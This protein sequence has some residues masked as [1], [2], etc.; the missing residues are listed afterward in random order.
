VSVFALKDA[1]LDV[2]VAAPGAAAPPGF[3]AF[4]R[5]LDGL[6]L[7]TFETYAH[8]R[9]RII[10]QQAE[11]MLELSTPVVKLWDGIVAVPLAQTFL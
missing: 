9:D 7:F 6:G 10:V 3:L 5:L 8:A 11:E 4:S 1:V 2:I